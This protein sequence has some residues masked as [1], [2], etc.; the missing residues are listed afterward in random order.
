MRKWA[1]KN[2]YKEIVQKLQKLCILHSNHGRTGTRAEGMDIS[3]SISIQRRDAQKFIFLYQW[4]KVTHREREMCNKPS[5]IYGMVHVFEFGVVSS[6]GGMIYVL[7]S[8]VIRSH[9]HTP[10]SGIFVSFVDVVLSRFLSA[11]PSEHWVFFIIHFGF[12]MNFKRIS[13]LMFCFGVV[14]SLPNLCPIF[15]PI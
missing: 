6:T 11:F 14:F 5:G 12:G 3:I 7:Y 9:S 10:M 15:L 4:A 8:A 1:Q 2:A 13:F